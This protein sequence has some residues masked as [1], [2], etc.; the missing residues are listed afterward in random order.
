MKELLV[1]EQISQ[2][3][4]VLGNPYRMEAANLQTIEYFTHVHD[5]LGTI[6]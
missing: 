3:L 5:Q 4:G 1:L 2:W 6:P